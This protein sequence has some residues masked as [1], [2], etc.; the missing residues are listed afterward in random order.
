MNTVENTFKS[1]AYEDQYKF[2]VNAV[3]SGE[4]IQ[5]KNSTGKIIAELGILFAIYNDAKL[6]LDSFDIK[7]IIFPTAA[8]VRQVF[9]HY[10]EDDKVMKKYSRDVWGKPCFNH[11]IEKSEKMVKVKFPNVNHCDIFVSPFEKDYRG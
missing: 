5:Y 4:N 8:Y 3:N 2:L 6:R 11:I 7:Y 10:Y 1:L 9:I